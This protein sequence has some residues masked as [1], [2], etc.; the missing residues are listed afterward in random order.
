[1]IFFLGVGSEQKHLLCSISQFLSLGSPLDFVEV[2]I[3]DPITGALTKLGEQGNR[4]I[5]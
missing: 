5:P 1:M 4:R 3:V 2:K